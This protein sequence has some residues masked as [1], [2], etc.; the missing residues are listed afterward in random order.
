M[1]IIIHT[2]WRTVSRLAG[3]KNYV[4]DCGVPNARSIE[5]L[6]SDLYLTTSEIDEY[7][8]AKLDLLI[9]KGS[10]FEEVCDFAKFYCYFDPFVRRSIWLDAIVQLLS[11][12]GHNVKVIYSKIDTS[13]GVPGKLRK[14]NVY[15]KLIIF[16]FIKTMIFFA[17]VIRLKI[18]NEKTGEERIDSEFISYP[19]LKRIFCHVVSENGMADSLSLLGFLMEANF[20]LIRAFKICY[21]YY[22]TEI[23]KYD[24]MHIGKLTFDDMNVHSAFASKYST[25]RVVPHGLNNEHD[26]QYAECLGISYG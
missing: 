26:K 4:Y 11:D 1:N 8:E 6:H 23:I 24:N 25:V 22:K 3:V 20:S 18:N 13:I 17:S 14:G 10:Q 9:N 5:L 16:I 19:K 21:S 12:R 15:H 2:S 7:I